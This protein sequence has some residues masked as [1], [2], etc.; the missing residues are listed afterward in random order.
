MSRL[1]SL[2]GHKFE[3]IYKLVRVG[4]EPKC[5]P[6]IQSVYQYVEGECGVRKVWTR[7]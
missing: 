4:C 1:S 6:W 3:Q 7:N 2:L 5:L